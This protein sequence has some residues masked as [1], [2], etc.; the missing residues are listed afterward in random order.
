MCRGTHRWA[1][2]EMQPQRALLS[3]LTPN[4]R[5]TVCL[6]YGLRQVTRPL[7]SPSVQRKVLSL[8]LLVYSQDQRVNW[9]FPGDAVHRNLLASAE[10]MGL[11]PGSGRFHMPQGN[12]AH[13]PQLLSPSSRASE[14]QL[15]SPHAAATEACTLCNP[16][17][18]S[19]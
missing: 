7:V 18:H 10:E 12:K 16:M 8:H 15:L 9:D 17:S 3:I 19:S 2:R 13:A 11:F 4:S 6:S 14:P 1:D 5:P